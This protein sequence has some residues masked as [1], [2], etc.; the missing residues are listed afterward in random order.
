MK[1]QNLIKAGIVVLCLG[2]TAGCS[3]G[4]ETKDLSE[5]TE[6]NIVKAETKTINEVHLRDVDLLYQNEDDTSVITMYLTVS[7]GNNAENTNHSWEEINTY[8][9]YD[10]NEMGVE[11]YQAAALLQVGDESGP[12]PGKLGYDTEIPNA[13]VQV[14]GQT[15]TRY[16]RKSYK[17]K[18]KDNKGTW[19]NQKTINL[20][21]HQQ[22]GMRFRNKLMYKLIQGIPQMIGLRTQFVHLYVRD[23][24]GPEPGQFEDYGLYT[25]VEQLNKSGLRAHGLDENGHLYKINFFGFYRYE[26]AIKLEDDPD[27]D[28]TQFEKLMEIK[29]SSD[30]TK[31]IAMLDDLNNYAIPAEDILDRYFDEKI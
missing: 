5:Q 29:G 8:S 10:Y 20:N 19:N 26:D 27:F 22:D 1:K 7:R 31:L 4:E 30:H 25:Q 23:D 11:R 2:M 12:Q 9:V 18:I 28:R 24:T 14:R 13:T 21:K 15:S 17:I 16:P 3:G 6:P